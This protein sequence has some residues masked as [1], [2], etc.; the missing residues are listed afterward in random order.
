MPSRAFGVNRWL[1]HLAIRCEN[2]QNRAR[3]EYIVPLGILVAFLAWIVATFS[4][5]HH[6]HRLVESAWLRWSKATQYRNECLLDF[7]VLFSGYL[8]RGDARPRNLRRLTDDSRRA[9]VASPELPADEALRTLSHAEKNLRRV[10]VNAVQIMENSA[11]M[12]EDAELSELSS[13]V[14]LSL[15]QQ[16][17]LTRVFNRSVGD[18]NL[19][20]SAPG[21][22]L[23]AGL[24][25]FSP[26]EELH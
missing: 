11:S 13:R 24:F 19:A 4:R 25:G 17:E 1:Y 9:M 22:R 18:F 14:S 12:R 7:T 15:F 23:V 16:D 3:M 8:P 26:L 21:A 5:L 20:L 2:R 10:V 6:L